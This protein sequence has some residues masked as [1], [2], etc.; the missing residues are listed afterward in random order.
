M[1]PCRRSSVCHLC[2]LIKLLDL[3]DGARF[4]TTRGPMGPCH[5]GRGT[6]AG[7]QFEMTGGHEREEFE[8]VLVKLLESLNARV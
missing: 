2:F 7:D 4:E 8:G 6:S 1:G 5:P 3:K